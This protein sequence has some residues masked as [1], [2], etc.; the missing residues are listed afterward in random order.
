MNI[1]FFGGH[2]WD[3]PWFRK[4]HFAKRLSDRGH[5]VFFVENTISMIRKKEEDKNKYFKTTYSKVNDNFYIITPSAIFPFPRNKFSKSL[6]NKKLFSD[7]KRILKKEKAED[8]IFWTNRIDIGSLYKEIRKTKIL[9]IC[10]DIP[11]YSKLAGDEKGYQYSKHFFELSLKNA[12]VPIVSAQKIKEKYQFLT[13]K[14]IIVIPNGHDISLNGNT[15]FSIPDDIKNIPSPR[16]GF[17]GTLFRFT[18]DELLKYL[19]TNRPEYSFIFVGGTETGFPI[20]KLKPY[21]NVHIIGKRLKEIIP[22]YIN[23]FDICLNTFKMHEVNDSVNPVKVFEYLALQ[24]PVVS[25]KMYSLMKEKISEYV[26]FANDYEDFLKKL[27][28]LVVNKSFFN[29]IPKQILDS[30]SWDSLFKKLI[31]EIDDK[32]SLHF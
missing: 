23:A 22:Q 20:E 17:I 12:D 16:L 27:D 2:Y 11:F 10:D 29:D 25:T 3:G 9:D 18:D 8:Y 1:L 24:K 30:Y 4:H 14:D 5:K 28:E 26:V 32:Y 7:I 31:C 6:Y 19:V 13:Q 15:T 21:K